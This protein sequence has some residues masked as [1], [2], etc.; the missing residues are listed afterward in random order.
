MRELSWRMGANCEKGTFS[1]AESYKFLNK[2]KNFFYTLVTLRH[3]KCFPR[4]FLVRRS[5][6]IEF[7]CDGEKVEE[8]D[9]S[10]VYTLTS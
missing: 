5:L 7:V 2:K 6:E 10:F 1:W 8:V 9:L 4:L 3:G